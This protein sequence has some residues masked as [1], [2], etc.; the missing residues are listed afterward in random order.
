LRRLNEALPEEVPDWFYMWNVKEAVA[1]RALAARSPGGRLVLP[2]GRD[3]WA[4][5]QA[6]ILIA[7]LRNSQY[8]LIGD[9]DQ[10]R[11]PPVTEPS[12]S[13]A[14]QSAEQ[15]LAAAVDAAAALVVNH[16]HK[17]HP[18]ARPQ[19][20]QGGQGGLVGR[21]EATVASSPRLKRTV[22]ELSSRSTAVRRLRMVA[23]QAL[24][25]TRVRRRS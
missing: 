17:A 1:H 12:A 22:R 5:E 21:V 16:Y 23:W 7:T 4:K 10:L 20:S 8:D 13:P 9:L 14:D 6:E 2:T 24:E 15:I 25:R 3:A 19:R 18:V 11:P